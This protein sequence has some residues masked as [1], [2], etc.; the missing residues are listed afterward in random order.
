MCD[1]LASDASHVVENNV[2]KLLDG[3]SEVGKFHVPLTFE[4]EHI[5][6]MNRAAKERTRRS[7]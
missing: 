4:D 1:G 3:I 5:N 2:A 6:M 7:Q